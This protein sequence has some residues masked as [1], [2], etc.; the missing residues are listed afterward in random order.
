MPRKTPSTARGTITVLA[1]VNGAG[2][3][4]VAGAYIRAA[5]GDYYNPDEF[6]RSL[7]L[8]NPGLDPAEANSL[9]W[10]RGKELLEHAIA[11]G[12]DFVFETT[13]GAKTIPRLLAGAATEGMAVKIFFVGLASV[14]HHL[15]RVAA[16]VANGGHNIPEAKIH[17]RWDHSRLNLVRLLPHL[18]ELMVWDNSAEADFVEGAPAPVLLLHLR[19]GKILAPKN[20]SSTPEWAK[21]IVAAALKLQPSR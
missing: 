16:R 18:A 19:N 15:R 7:L 2:K 11:T 13:L 12:D 5:G 6:T 21:P 14:E 8:S 10:M 9:A 4:S 20:L 1:G 3:S 17:E